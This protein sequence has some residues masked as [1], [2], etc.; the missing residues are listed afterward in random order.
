MSA[1]ASAQPATALLPGER[2]LASWQPQLQL[3]AHRALLLSFVTALALASLGYLTWLQWLIAVPVFTVIFVV[4]FDDVSTWFRHRHD[5]WHLTDRRLIYERLDAPEENA[6]VALDKIDWLRPWAWW[7]LRI[8]FVAGTA[9]TMQ[10]VPRPRDI[11]A[12]IL[13]AKAAFEDGKHDR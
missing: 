2:L 9:T 10:F 11:R 3:F 12:R 8:G 6:A 4:I 13:D 7:A 1:P 5:R